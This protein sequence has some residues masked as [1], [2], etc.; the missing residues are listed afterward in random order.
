[1]SPVPTLTDIEAARAKVA[2]EISIDV[3]QGVNVPKTKEA[4]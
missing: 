2:S 1:M 3:L 4:G